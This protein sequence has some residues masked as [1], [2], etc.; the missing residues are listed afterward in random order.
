MNFSYV[1]TFLFYTL[2]CIGI[3]VVGF[4]IIS[5]IRSLVAARK[6]KDTKK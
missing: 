1:L 5:C 4:K 2:V 6:S 3:G